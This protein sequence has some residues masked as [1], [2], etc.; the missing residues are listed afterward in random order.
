MSDTAFSKLN[1]RQKRTVAL[2]T[3][4]TNSQTYLNR[5][6]AYRACYS[7]TSTLASQ[8]TAAYRLFAKPDIQAAIKELLPSNAY[9]VLFIR[10]EYLDHYEKA[11]SEDDRKSCLAIL[12]EMA[13]H[14]GMLVKQK[15]T[16]ELSQERKDI[17]ALK[18]KINKNNIKREREMEM[19]LLDGTKIKQA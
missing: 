18:A 19:R 12:K 15:D 9:D 1:Q 13:I 7:S 8:K 6:Q 11:K 10:Q 16:A 3:N 17:D 14:E 5:L 4:E 2:Y